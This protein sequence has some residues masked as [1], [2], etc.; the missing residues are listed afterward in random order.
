MEKKQKGP[1]LNRRPKSGFT[2]TPNFGV[3][4][5]FKSER[6]F[7]LIELLVVISIIALLASIVLVA[8]SNSRA[9]A[10][11]ARRIA[12]IKQLSSAMELFYGDFYSYPTTTSL[13]AA[14][15]T[16]A[17]SAGTPCANGT[18]GCVN[19]M[20]P[21]YLTKIPVAPLPADGICGQAYG[22]GISTAND[23]QFLSTNAN[24]TTST[25]QI[26]FCLGGQ[27]GSYI[28]GVHTLTPTGIQ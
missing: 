21:T 12:D 26:T 5:D 25:Y 3:S 2:P 24:T 17:F 23:Y 7:T 15:T 10:R 28:P 22:S 11:D 19:Y 18:A 9:K 14:G 8:L 4:S 16:G 20:V 1:V 13:V 27:T 6:G